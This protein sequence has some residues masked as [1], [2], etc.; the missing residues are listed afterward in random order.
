MTIL[1]AIAF[2]TCVVAVGAVYTTG[3]LAAIGLFFVPFMIVG[4][5]LDYPWIEWSPI[6]RWAIAWVVCI[7]V[8]IPVVWLD[9]NP[10]WMW[11]P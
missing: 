11:F 7:V 5:L 8:L 1:D 2:V 10:G 4:E 3:A 6:R 9:G